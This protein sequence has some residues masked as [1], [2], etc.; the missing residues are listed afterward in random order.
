VASG[1]W[2][3]NRLGGEGRGGR[4]SKGLGGGGSGGEGEKGDWGRKERTGIGEGLLL[5]VSR[6]R[7]TQPKLT[8]CEWRVDPDKRGSRAQLQA[9]RPRPLHGLI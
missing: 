9:G 1:R 6:S 5:V 4:P 8:P 7:L 2:S 3:R